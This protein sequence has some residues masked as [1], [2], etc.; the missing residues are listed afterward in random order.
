METAAIQ[1]RDQAGDEVAMVPFSAR[2]LPGAHKLSLDLRWPYR[3]D[4]W[5]FAIELGQGFVLER[6]GE[7]LGTAAWFPYGDTCATI[8]M[9]IV[10]DSVQGRGYGARLMDALLAAAGPRTILLNATPEGQALYL[11]RGFR[12]VGTI[13][14]HQGVVPAT[15]E[16]AS[17]ADIVRPM[18]PEDFDAMLRR[19]RE[20]TGFE[21]RPLLERLLDVGEADVLRRD[22]EVAGYAVSRVWG[23]GHVVGPVVAPT[24]QDARLLIEAALSRLRGRFVRIDT[25]VETGLSPWLAEIGLLQVSDALVMVLGQ[26]P[27]TGPARVFALSNQSLN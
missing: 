19:D 24:P 17:T 7:V 5:A 8:G 12:P 4:D 16:A 25:D 1:N 22:G 6:Q 26:M 14:Q 10:A 13:H 23:R 18:V 2:H 21:R 27:P 20:A 11:R 15:F 3:L 9:I